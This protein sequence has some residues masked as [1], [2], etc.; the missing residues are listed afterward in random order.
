MGLLTIAL[1]VLRLIPHG[2]PAQHKHIIDWSWWLVLAPI[3]IPAAIA[4]AVLGIV[5]LFVV[6]RKK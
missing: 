3:W 6:T 5:L 1:I 4:L 2:D